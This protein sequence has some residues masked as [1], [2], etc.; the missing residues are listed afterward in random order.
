[1]AQVV[2]PQQKGMGPGFWTVTLIMTAIN[3]I[4]GFFVTNLDFGTLIPEASD[5]AVDIDNLF[6]FMAVFGGAITVYV[7]GYIVYFCIV[8]RRRAT[9]PPDAIGIQIHDAPALEIW[10]TIIPAILLAVLSW[11]SVKVWAQIQFG[12]ATATALSTEVIAHQ[13]A[14]SFRYPGLADPVDE[15]HLPIGKPVHLIVTST[16]V[17]HSFW[18]PDMRLKADT[19]PGITQ[20][21]NFTPTRLGTYTIECTE[22]CGLAHSQMSGKLVVESPEQ[23]QTWLDRQK[24]AQSKAAAPSNPGEKK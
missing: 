15:M 13:F 12:T 9:D 2:A 4:W 3:I 7:T 1:M 8:W 11:L 21:L 18:V 14:Y 20:Y 19:V 10:W 23:F 17:I 24:L 16:D 6:K 22:F 5:R